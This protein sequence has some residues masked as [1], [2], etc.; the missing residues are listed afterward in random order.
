MY[1]DTSTP[2]TPKVFVEKNHPL[3]IKGGPSARRLK[4]TLVRSCP[5][6]TRKY[7]P[8]K[9]CRRESPGEKRGFFSSCG[10]FVFFGGVGWILVD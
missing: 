2:A 1:L 8:Q 10:V 5:P 9:W 7:K 6:T 3:S 4:A